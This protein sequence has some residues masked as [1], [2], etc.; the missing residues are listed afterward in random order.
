MDVVVAPDEAVLE[1]EAARTGGSADVSTSKR[2][3]RATVRVA[4]WVG[5]MREGWSS[6][7]DAVLASARTASMRQ[8]PKH[9]LL[10]TIG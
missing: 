9:R 8:I 7:V 4:A 2:D 10:S 3:G 6:P 5:Q 1:R